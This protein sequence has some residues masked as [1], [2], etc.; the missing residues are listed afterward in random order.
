MDKQKLTTIKL[1][2]CQYV[3]RKT[4]KRGRLDTYYI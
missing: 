2:R 4:K 3:K 1:C